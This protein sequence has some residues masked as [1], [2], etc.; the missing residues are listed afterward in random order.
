MTLVALADALC[1]KIAVE[2]RLQRHD[3]G[4]SM[5]SSFKRRLGTET[6][7]LIA[8]YL[9]ISISVPENCTLDVAVA[10]ELN[11]GNLESDCQISPYSL[12]NISE[13]HPIHFDDDDIKGTFH[14]TAAYLSYPIAVLANAVDEDRKVRGI[15]AGRGGIY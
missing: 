10:V 3:S 5:L 11:Y 1:A 8:Q 7:F 13:P 4:N 14:F 6:P 12:L 9:L 15:Y 2:V